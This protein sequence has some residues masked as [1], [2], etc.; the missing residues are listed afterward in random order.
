MN[1]ALAEAL[2]EIEKGAERWLR[3]RRAEF[4]QLQQELGEDQKIV[5]HIEKKEEPDEDVTEIIPTAKDTDDTTTEE[6]NL[7]A[8]PR[9]RV[10]QS[11]IALK[12]AAAEAK[13]KEQKR[14]WDE[15]TK[16]RRATEEGLG[17]VDLEEAMER[18]E[19]PKKAATD[20]S[21]MAAETVMTTAATASSSTCV[22]TAE[23]Y[24]KPYASTTESRGELSKARSEQKDAKEREL[25]LQRQKKEE[26]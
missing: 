14:R 21:T 2:D 23:V 13:V 24:A 10:T 15:A 9:K 26:E 25:M 18:T 20:T 6:E 16:W 1:L 5:G 19:N 3:A 8:G 4:Q 7:L 11:I 22:V 17:D 12:K